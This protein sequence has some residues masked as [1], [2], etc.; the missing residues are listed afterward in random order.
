MS[1]HVRL[2]I[3]VEP[4]DGEDAMFGMEAYYRHRS[5]AMKIIFF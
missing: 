2:P 1:Y 3:R 5:Y 4:I